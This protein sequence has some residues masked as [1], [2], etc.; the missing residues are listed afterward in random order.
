M[1]LS[2]MAAARTNKWIRRIGITSILLG[3][4]AVSLL[5]MIHR[6]GGSISFGGPSSQSLLSAL[7]DPAKLSASV[8][9]DD[10]RMSRDATTPDITTRSFRV[11]SVDAAKSAI[12]GACRAA[13]L[14]PP[15][16]SDMKAMRDIICQGEWRGADATVHLSSR[17]Q[18][19]CLAMLE[20]SLI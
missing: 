10:F 12:L 8:E 13:G 20:V 18:A 14:S 6:A 15:S 2:M 11:Q 9:A 1:E 7:A 3:W 4:G 16:S 5:L 17:C 19:G